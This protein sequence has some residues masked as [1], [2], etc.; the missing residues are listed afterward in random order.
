[1]KPGDLV[2]ILPRPFLENRETI[3][4]ILKY[5]NEDPIDIVPAKVIVLGHV[6]YVGKE[7]IKPLRKNAHVSKNKN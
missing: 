1:M 6:T 2:K 4:M 3:G 5:D 7:Y